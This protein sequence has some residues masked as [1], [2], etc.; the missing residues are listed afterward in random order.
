MHAGDVGVDDGLVVTANEEIIEMM[1]GC[2]C[3]TG[4]LVFFMYH[5]LYLNGAELFFLSGR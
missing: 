3:C 2:I 4:T 5:A 1:N